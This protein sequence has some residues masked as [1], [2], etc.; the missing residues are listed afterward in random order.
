MS[1][2]PRVDL[3]TALVEGQ[4]PLEPLRAELRT[5]PWDLDEPLVTL[6][7]SHVEAILDRFL[8]GEL[9]AAAVDAWANAIELRDDIGFADE[10]RDTL[11]HAIFVLANPDV[12][13][14][15]TTKRA[16]ALLAEITRRTS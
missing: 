7:P 13:G 6:R 11:A 15:L 10:G 9:T 16:E 1:S 12:N 14:H 4:F 3:V 8:K 5:Y 2:R